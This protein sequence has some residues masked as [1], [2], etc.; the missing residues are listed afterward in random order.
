M[1]HIRAYE[2]PAPSFPIAANEMYGELLLARGEL[3]RMQHNL[4]CARSAWCSQAISYWEDRVIAAIDAVF[5][6]QENYKAS[7]RHWA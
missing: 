7:R 5:E 2:L 1:L 3:L 4:A 6:A